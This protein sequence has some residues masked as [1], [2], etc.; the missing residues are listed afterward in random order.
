MY[1][2]I[3]LSVLLASVLPAQDATSPEEAALAARGD[4]A[5]ALAREG[6]LERMIQELKTCQK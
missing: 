1:L 4:L 2:R 5:A 3:I 6:L